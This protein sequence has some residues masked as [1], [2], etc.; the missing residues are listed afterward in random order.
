MTFK[1]LQVTYKLI[2]ITQFMLTTIIINVYLFNYLCFILNNK[3]HVRFNGMCILFPSKV[4]HSNVQ[5]PPMKKIE[6]SG[7]RLNV[8]QIQR[9]HSLLYAA[10]G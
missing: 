3:N 8:A 6:E 9:C 10:N 2:R 4:L 5:R 1:E 7:I